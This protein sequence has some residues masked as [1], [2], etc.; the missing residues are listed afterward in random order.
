MEGSI[1]NLLYL[2]FPVANSR[3]LVCVGGEKQLKCSDLV[4]SD[5]SLS[6]SKVDKI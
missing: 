5:T 1:K 3:S 2:S 4:L 6:V